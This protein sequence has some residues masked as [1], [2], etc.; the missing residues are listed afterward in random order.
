MAATFQWSESNGA[1]QVVTDGISNVNFGNVDAPNIVPASNPIAANSNSFEK[2]VRGKFSG[3]FNSIANL[4]FW[5]S[6]GTYVT[7]EDIKAAVNASY[8]TPVSTASIVAT[9]TVPIVEGSALVPAAPS[10]NPDYSGY[11]TM[12]LQTTSSTPP[13]NV[14]QKTFTLKYDET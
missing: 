3:V 6:L 9:V 12:Q 14:N 13:G 1:G 11:I 4:R 10:T 5:K 8:A 2:W 7:G